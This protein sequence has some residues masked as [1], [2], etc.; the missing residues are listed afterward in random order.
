MNI[1]YTKYIINTLRDLIK[2]AAQFGDRNWNW[3]GKNLMFDY[4]GI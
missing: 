1:Y 4:R 2:L 3:R